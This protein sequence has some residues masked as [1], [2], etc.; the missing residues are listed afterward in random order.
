MDSEFPEIDLRVQQ[1]VM[2]HRGWTILIGAVLSLI[3]LFGLIAPLATSLGVVWG[4]GVVLI[5]AGAFQF[6]HAWQCRHQK[7]G[8]WAR[9]LLGLLSIV[10]GALV[11]RRP[12]LGALALS[13]LVSLYLFAS[14][15]AQLMM[16]FELKPAKGWGWMLF[17][18]IISLILGIVLFITLPTTSFILPGVFFGIYLLFYGLSLMTFALLEGHT[19]LFERQRRYELERQK[20]QI[21]EQTQAR[22]RKQMEMEEQKEEQKKK[23]AA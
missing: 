22:R 11:I 13:L 9:P 2:H 12:F 10:C 4:L 6:I 20:Q 7:D 1:M 19:E 3:G 5:V 17:S 21:E 8:R 23:K 14:G 18:S 16:A 15:A